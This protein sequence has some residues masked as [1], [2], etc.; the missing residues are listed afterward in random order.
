M[1]RRLNV[2]VFVLLALMIVRIAVDGFTPDLFDGSA[3]LES[4]LFAALAAYFS[5]RQCGAS[6]C[7]RHSAPT[8]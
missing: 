4:A 3:L 7:Q 6:S 1:S 2:F 8:S 5:G